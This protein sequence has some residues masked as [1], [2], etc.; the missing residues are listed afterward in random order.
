MLCQECKKRPATVHWT[1]IVNNNKTEFHLCEEC[2]RQKGQ[3]NIIVPFS[4][5]DLLA[6]FMDMEKPAVAVERKESYRCKTCGL[7]FRKFRQIGRLGCQDC[8]K[9]FANELAPILKRIQGGTRHTGKVPKRAGMGLRLRREI[10]Q[11]KAQ[12]QKAIET[13][14]FE[15]AAQLRDQIRELEKQAGGQ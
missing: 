11:L 3:F 5:N 15:K 10:E 2:A 13:E 8:Y 14:A 12:L 1:K 6:G 7:D 9:S 4:I